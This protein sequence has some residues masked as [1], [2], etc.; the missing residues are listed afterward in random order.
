MGRIVIGF[1]AIAAG[2]A[3]GC[4]AHA[5][6]ILVNKTGSPAPERGG[7][8]YRLVE[9]A[10]SQAQADDVIS[11]GAGQYREAL[12]I[13]PGSDGPVTLTA[14]GGSAEI[15][16]F[17]NNG[18]TTLR[19]LSYNTHLFG[20]DDL[21]PLDLVPDWQDAARAPKIG[22][23]IKEEAP[24]VALLQE[25]WDENLAATILTNAGPP[26]NSPGHFLHGN[27]KDGVADFLLKNSGLLTMSRTLLFEPVQIDYES[28]EDTTVC[29]TALVAAASA[30]AV[31]GTSFPAC[32]SNPICDGIL[33]AAILA[34]EPVIEAF[35][36]KGYIRA[37]VVKDSFSFILYN[38][39]AQAFYNEEQTEVRSL[40]MLELGINM[41][42]YHASHPDHAIIAG[43]DFNIFG[44]DRLAGTTDSNDN[45][46]TAEYTNALI[47]YVGNP[48][49]GNAHDAI[50]NA[51]FFDKDDRINIWTVITGPN[52]PTNTLNDY[53]ENDS[54]YNEDGE[55]FNKGS[56][57][58]LDFIFFNGDQSSALD[59][60]PKLA[61]LKKLM[62]SPAI[63]GDGTNG[64]G[65]T[66]SNLSDHY[67]VEMTFEVYRN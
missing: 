39:H 65:H 57:G 27:R 17:T 53:F 58:R 33:A 13:D 25:V 32:F 38:T 20:P 34:C 54:D 61:A 24:D 63:T 21:G 45:T 30:L 31:H 11:I 56:E 59:V 18:K 64:D 29:D 67:G 42:S 6:T 51:P 41:A 43:G 36:S 60:L 37:R 1:V 50:R 26:Y 2:L 14:T 44:D 52:A 9:S 12:T 62:T 46:L 4:F 49:L 55:D 23:R 10:V 15:G 8:A 5:E 47:A 7:S 3:V 22:Q 28:E 16:N 48:I 40:Q 19:V 66:D 35:S